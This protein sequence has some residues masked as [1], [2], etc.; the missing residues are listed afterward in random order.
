MGMAESHALVEFGVSGRRSDRPNRLFFCR[1]PLHSLIVQRIQSHSPGNDTILYNPTSASPKHLHYFSRL[2]ADRS[3]FVPFRYPLNSHVAAEIY[4]FLS[5]PSDLRRARYDE[6]H[7][8]SIGSLAFA[9]LAGRNPGAS[10]RTFDDGTFNVRRQHFESWVSDEGPAYHRLIWRQLSALRNC[11]VVARA[12]RHYTIFDPSFS[13]FNE[14]EI[15]RVELFPEMDR[16]GAATKRELIVVLGTPIHLVA[17][18]KAELYSKYV[19]SLAPDVYIPHPA[20]TGTQTYTPKQADDPELDA[21]MDQRIAEEIVWL[22]RRRGHALEIHG[23]GSTALINVASLGNASNHLVKG[24]DRE[25]AALF[26]A[27]GI[28]SDCPF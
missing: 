18:H 16:I 1:T 5:I 22:L 21:Y 15:V 24:E 23:F 6:M 17:P 3:F 11:E 9:A 19:Q 27:F 2:K 12:D 28:N 25:Q 26:A 10:L 4:A 8:A 14:K 13:L 7:L 20:E